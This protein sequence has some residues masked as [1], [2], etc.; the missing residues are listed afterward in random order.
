MGGGGGGGAWAS[1]VWAA[2]A[3]SGPWALKDKGMQKVSPNL[4]AG[5]EVVRG[6]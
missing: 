2:K 5:C 1:S 3:L 6:V 4:P